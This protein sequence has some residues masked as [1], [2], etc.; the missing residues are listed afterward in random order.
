MMHEMAASSLARTCPGPFQASTRD[1]NG[2]CPWSIHR[3]LTTKTTTAQCSVYRTNPNQS[4]VAFSATSNATQVSAIVGCV[5]EA[6]EEMEPVLVLGPLRVG[7]V[8]LSHQRL[9]FDYGRVGHRA[10][11]ACRL[12][13]SL[14]CAGIEQLISEAGGLTLSGTRAARSAAGIRGT[15]CIFQQESCSH[16]RI[17]ALAH[18][19]S[20]R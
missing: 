7:G 1:S 2:S 3:Q 5:N 6:K 20:Y 14:S 11:T 9:A 10:R 15:S 13:C 19:H 4:P 16:T 12:C 17:I 18:S 8:F